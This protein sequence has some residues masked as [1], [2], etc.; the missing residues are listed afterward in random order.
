MIIVILFCLI[1]QGSLTTG[2]EGTYNYFYRVYF[3]DKGENDIYDYTPSELFSTRAIERR[4]K[5]GIQDLD[6][7]DLPVYRE[8]LEIISSWGLKLHSTSRWMNTALFKTQTLTEISNLMN[9]NFVKDVKIVKN[10]ASKAYHYDKLH[11]ETSQADLPPF[12][13]PV[14]MLNGQKVHRSGFIGK[15][16]LI[17]VLDGGFKNADNI[18]SLE[19][20]RKRNGIKGTFDFVR[21]D[22]YVYDF[23]NHGTAVLSILAGN[24]PGS[25]EGS[26][27][28]ADYWLLRTEDTESE[29]PVE[30]DFWIAGAE[31]ADSIGADIISSSLGYFT[32]DDPLFDYKYSDMDGNSTF[33]TRAADVA[34]SKGILVVSSAGNERNKP[35]IHIIS[36]SDGDSILAVGAVDGYQIISSFSSAGPSYDGRI[37]PD[38]V[39][40]GVS[41]PIQVETSDVIRSNGTSFSCPL[42]SGMSACIMQ[43]VPLATNYDIITSLHSSSDRYL[44]PDSLYGY[45]I[46]DIAE[47][48]SQLQEMYLVKPDN[49]SVI[50]PNP[51]DDE[52]QIIFREIPEKLRIEIFNLNGR[53][54][55][56]MDYQT[57]ITRSLKIRDFHNYPK[58]IYFV[59]VTTAAGTFIHKVI[60]YDR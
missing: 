49:G 18:T 17:V 59:R 12:N 7:M 31:F 2:Q 6:F 19:A 4:Q 27:T 23:H 43:A 55:T 1:C 40:Q 46:P 29:F 5:N 24:I 22:E 37:K 30:E 28:G 35:W 44:S 32:F 51:F 16:I 8:Y 58:G 47:T 11:F 60:R 36:P 50:S 13:Q 41:V 38:V 52:I 57:Y 42:I 20:I 26:A 14:A 15:S 54:L 48:I 45:G 3:K 21:N 53:L 56:R 25:I 10:V 39:A 9:H 34:A 33:I